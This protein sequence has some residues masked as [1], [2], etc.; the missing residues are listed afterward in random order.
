MRLAATLAAALSVLVSGA[1][2]EPARTKR[3][4]LTYDDAPMGDGPLLSGDDRATQLIDGLKA[5]G[6]DQAAFF[7]AT[8]GFETREGGRARVA[9]YAE[10]G[11]VLANHT[12]THP[13]AHKTDVAAYIA[14]IDRADGLLDGFP[15]RRAWFRFPYL[16]E[17]RERGKRDALRTAL[18]ERGL[19][20]AYVTVDNYDWHMVSLARSAMKDGRCIDRDAA[21]AVYV[22]MLVD[23]AEHFDALARDVLG[24]SPAHVLLLHENDFAALYVTR[25]VDGLKAAGWTIVTADEAFSD[26]MADRPP[27]TVFSGMGRVAAY[28]QDAGLPF[29]RFAHAASDEAAIAARFDAAGVVVDCPADG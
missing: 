29:E 6:V 22:D 4:A 3:I 24:R 2:A 26:P 9:R 7:I 10:A 18:A 14:E 23:A 17:G 8:R 28:G 20:N 27:D 21:G 19:K 16:D 1:A 11:H 13:W 12:H 15:N 5:A 25:L